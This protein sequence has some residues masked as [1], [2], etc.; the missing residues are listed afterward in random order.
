MKKKKKHK[1]KFS[2]FMNPDGGYK[3]ITMVHKDK[4]KYNK[5]IK[6]EKDEDF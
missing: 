1:L 5:K 6:P 4:K 3:R 2:R